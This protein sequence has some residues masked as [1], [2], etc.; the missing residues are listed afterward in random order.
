MRDSYASCSSAC[1][2]DKSITNHHLQVDWRSSSTMTASFA[3]YASQFLNRQQHPASSVSSTSQPLF[4]SFTTDNGSRAD[5]DPFDFREDVEMGDDDDPHLRRSSELFQR[6]RETENDDDDPYLRLDED[7]P[8][9]SRTTRTVTESIPLIASEARSSVR[10]HAQGWLAHQ[11]ATSYR[12]PTPTP[13]DTSSESG[14]P[15]PDLILSTS[16][17]PPPPQTAQGEPLT[18]SLLPRDGVSRPLDVFSLPDPR[19][20]SRGRASHKDAIWTTVWLASVT[21]CVLGSFIILFTTKVPRGTPRST[22]LPYTTLLH[23]IP[24]ITILTFLSAAV[25]YAHIMLLRLFVKPVIFATS[26]FIP[27]ALFISALWAFIGSFMWEEGTEPTWGETVG[28][29]QFFFS[30]DCTC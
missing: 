17:V 25:S 30:C 22:I 26:V 16:N 18:E 28:C 24:L 27:A 23:A 19:R 5:D 1:G 21:A 13:S 9:M 4:F 29:V 15:P 8:Q 6:G 11:A 10:D 14:V 12:H 2:P 7:E 3:A 20:H